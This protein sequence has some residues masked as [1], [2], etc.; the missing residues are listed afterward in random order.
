MS[1]HTD[2]LKRGPLP[3]RMDPWAEAPHYFQQLHASLIG[4]AIEELDPLL[5]ARGFRLGREASLQIAE[6]REPDIFIQR[7]MHSQLTQ[8]TLNYE[9]AA[10]ELLLDPGMMLQDET[11]WQAITIRALGSGKLVTVIEFVSPG[12]KE[13]PSAVLDYQQR[14]ERLVV[15]QG[16][17]VVEIDLTRSVKRLVRSE[18]AQQT[19]YHIAVYVPGESPRLIGMAFDQPLKPFAVPLRQ[20]VVP[21]TLHAHYERAYR[22]L[23]LAGQIADDGGYTE[24]HL[25]FPATLNPEQRQHCLAAV[26]RWRDHLHRLSADET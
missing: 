12:N 25:P 26:Q 14:R 13:R 3:G 5:T 6:G 15:E 16:V 4:Y 8:P 11:E 2:W 19:A 22:A 7:M 9:L 20:D 21:L 1:A 24:E 23:T 10:A 18:I 17:N